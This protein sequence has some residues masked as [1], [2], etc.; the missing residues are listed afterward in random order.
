MGAHHPQSRDSQRRISRLVA[1]DQ[2]QVH[3]RQAVKVELHRVKAAALVLQPAEIHLSQLGMLFSTDAADN[4]ICLRH[5]AVAHHRALFLDDPRLGGGNVRKSGA[6]L[7]HMII[8]SAV[9]TAH[10]GA[11]M[12]LVESSVPPRPTSSTTI[13]HFCWAK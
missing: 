12:T 1:A 3:I 8:P 5:A 2:G 9:M 11:S 13:S 7:L 6:K 10:S 4:N